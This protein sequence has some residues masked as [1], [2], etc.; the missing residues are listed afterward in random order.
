MDKKSN[1]FSAISILG[2]TAVGAILGSAAGKA[3]GAGIGAG[4]GAGV[5]TT[6]TFLKKGREARIK[7][8][9]EFEIVLNKEVT[10][11]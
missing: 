8:N 10:V 3:K 11:P 6:A 1:T 2:G 4:V 7:A 5:G 9:Q